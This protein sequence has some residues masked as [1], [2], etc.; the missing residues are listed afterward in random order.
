M[1]LSADRMVLSFLLNI[2][3]ATCTK[4]AKNMIAGPYTNPFQPRAT[5]PKQ[6]P[7]AIAF[8]EAALLS[9]RTAD[10]AVIIPEGVALVVRDSLSSPPALTALR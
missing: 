7:A 8:A 3:I 6:T 4:Y 5:I 10:I 9:L 2:F 1:I